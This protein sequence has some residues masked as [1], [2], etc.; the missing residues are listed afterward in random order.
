MARKATDTK[1]RILETATNLFSTHGYGGTSVDDILTAV[2]I[3]KGAFYHYFKSKDTLCEEILDATV[4]QYH[5]LA[6]S[7]QDTEAGPAG[8][9]DW[10]ELLME[11]Q[12]S[13]QWLHCR[14]VTRLSVESAELNASMQNKLRT[15]WLWCQSLHETLIR[16]AIQGTEKEESVDPAMT[17]RL[18][19]SAHFGSLWLDRCAPAKEDLAGVCENL[20]RQF[21]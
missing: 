4:N 6:K 13:G 14:L 16:R 2:G 21:T 19:I 17:A 5:Q 12:S 7:V 3:T 15:F 11:K 18:F 9:H 8:L 20:L 1:Q 10:L